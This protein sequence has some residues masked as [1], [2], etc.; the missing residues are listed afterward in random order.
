MELTVSVAPDV[1]GAAGAVVPGSIAGD[2]SAT[3][4]LGAGAGA[5]GVAASA[6][7]VACA[8]RAVASSDAIAP[9][10]R[11]CFVRSD[12]T[13]P[14]RFARACSSDAAV[15]AACCSSVASRSTRCA[16][17]ADSLSRRARV[18]VVWSTTL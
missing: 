13:S 1:A 14:V 5:V 17:S 3:G 10:F 2:G 11:R 8:A 18:F 12:A 4:T 16:S 15:D 6:T 7:D 9:L